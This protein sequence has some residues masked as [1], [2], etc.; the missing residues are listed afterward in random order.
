MTLIPLGFSIYVHFSLKGKRISQVTR[1]GAGRFTQDELEEEQRGK[2]RQAYD[3]IA[4]SY[5]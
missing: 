4:L 2:E 3:T 5:M 1:R